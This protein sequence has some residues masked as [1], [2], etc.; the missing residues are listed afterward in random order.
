MSN[1]DLKHVLT[2]PSCHQV[3]NRKSTVWPDF[4]HPRALYYWARQLVRFHGL[5]PYDGAWIVSSLGM[6]H[7]TEGQGDDGGARR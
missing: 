7:L 6:P 2:R 5:V 3:W 4:S 1:T